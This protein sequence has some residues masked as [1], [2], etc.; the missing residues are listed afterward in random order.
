MTPRASRSMHSGISPFDPHEPST[1][2]SR[3]TTDCSGSSTIGDRFPIRTTVPPFRT[4]R[5]AVATVSPWPTTSNAT[6]APRPPVRLGDRRRHVDGCRIHRLRGAHS[7]RQFELPRVD[8]DR[9]DRADALRLQ[10]LNR[11]QT[12]HPGADDDRRVVRPPARAD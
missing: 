11:Q 12:D 5:I 4:L 6:S 1:A 8:V 3:V 7:S 9:H 10:H 2:I